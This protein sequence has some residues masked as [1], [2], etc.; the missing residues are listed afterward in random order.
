MAQEDYKSD[1]MQITF[2]LYLAVEKGEFFSLI[3]RC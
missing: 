3:I 1:E 2:N